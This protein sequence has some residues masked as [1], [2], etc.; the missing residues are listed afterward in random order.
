MLNTAKRRGVSLF[1]IVLGVC[2]VEWASSN[3]DHARRD[4]PKD[5][6]SYT[7]TDRTDLL[8]A[9]LGAMS[10]TTFPSFSVT[11]AD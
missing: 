1:A 4:A 8:S 10:V 11:D 9:A 6:A 5:S 2:G 7:T 3:E